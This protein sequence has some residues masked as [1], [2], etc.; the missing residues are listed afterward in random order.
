MN[1]WTWLHGEVVVV[2]AVFHLLL[3]VWDTMSRRCR[4]SGDFLLNEGASRLPLPPTEQSQAG[5]PA[6]CE[7][8]CRLKD[9]TVLIRSVWI[10]TLHTCLLVR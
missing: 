4:T 6:V 5:V 8:K 3:P 7:E 10:V 1:A 9:L 2:S